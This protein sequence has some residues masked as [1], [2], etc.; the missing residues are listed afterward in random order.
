M[1]RWMFVACALPVLLACSSPEEMGEG[2][3]G[4]QSEA[5]TER[6]TA[7]PPGEP[8]PGS[9]SVEENETVEFA[10]RW[11]QEAAALPLLDRLLRERASEE[12]RSFTAMATEAK[13]DAEKYD[14]PYRRYSLDIGVEVI[15]DTPRFLSMLEG[16][17]AY[18]GGAHGN[19]DYAPLLWDRRAQQ[20]LDPAVLF[21]S[22]N[23]LEEA[24]R[25]RYCQRLQNER[26]ARLG[27][28]FV[29]GIDMFD[30]CPGFSELA[31]VV[32][33]SSGD[34]MD[35]IDF[36]AAPYVAGS[37]AEG[38]YIITVPINEAIMAAISDEFRSAF[39]RSVE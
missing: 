19:S 27:A 25:E 21:T 12:M 15:A 26:G 31:I 38:A 30:S 16:R 9:F 35:Q 20:L 34:A 3:A 18:T 14:Y 10:S 8:G 29:E 17:Y 22:I 7:R 24:A 13:A 1:V 33:S 36:V 37:Y 4:E 5:L 23:A 6:L 39:T 28:E 11:P 32:K 2:I